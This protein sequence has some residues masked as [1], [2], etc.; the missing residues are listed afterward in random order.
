MREVAFIKQNKEKW[1]S[2]EHRFFNKS[3]STPEELASLY[4][5]IVNDLAFAQTFYP[6]SKT[7]E[8]LNKLA[9][10]AYLSIYKTKRIEKNRFIEFF[11]YEIPIVAYTYRKYILYS[12]IIFSLFVL[13]GATS[14]AVDET[15]VRIILGDAYVNT[16]KEN[17]KNGN[18][19][20]IY[21]SGS[22][23]GSFI[24]ITANNIYV[25]IRCFL[26]GI[27]GGF[28][29]G[30]F[31]MYNGIMLGSFQ[32]MFYNEGVLAES[33][34]G[35]WIHGAMEIFSIIISGASGLILGASILFPKTFSRFQSFKRGFK[36]G[37]IL[38]LSAIPFLI[39]A[40]FLEGYITRYS[41]RMPIWLSLSIIIGTFSIIFYYYIIYPKI[42]NKKITTSKNA[43]I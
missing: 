26:Y 41:N 40:G 8:Y 38:L 12:F 18:P 14:T 22:E 21:E 11:K 33:M 16:T 9:A 29:T 37:F 32:Y 15:Y 1:L 6:K 13:I 3:D 23:F 24:L 17:I 25:S 35:I 10:N 19:V 39:F 31:L 43:T 34:R 42:V 36:D 30:I 7:V 27:F 4:I 28:G 2:F 5:E 20:A